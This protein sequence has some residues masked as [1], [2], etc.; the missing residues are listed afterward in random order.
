MKVKQFS[1]C[2]TSYNLIIYRESER[3]VFILCIA[4]DIYSYS[5]KKSNCSPYLFRT[6]QSNQNRAKE[7]LRL[8]I[9]LGKCQHAQ[10]KKTK[11]KQ[12]Q[13]TKVLHTLQIIYS[14]NSCSKPRALPHR[15][16]QTNPIQSKRRK[17][18]ITRWMKC[19]NA[20]FYRSPRRQSCGKTYN[21]YL[22]QQHLNE[23]TSKESTIKGSALTMKYP[24]IVY[25]KD[26]IDWS[27]CVYQFKSFRL[28][29]E[30]QPWD[31]HKCLSIDMARRMSDNDNAKI[32]VVVTSTKTDRTNSHSPTDYDSCC[33]CWWWWSI[34]MIGSTVLQLLLLHLSLRVA[35][36]RIRRKDR[37][38]RL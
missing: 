6:L 17:L 36:L 16:S 2:H 9:P 37:G 34:I 21:W 4:K 27:V 31:S 30:E 5:P 35:A 22:T 29:I 1:L 28:H 24:A 19:W 25:V 14:T 11:N 32:V 33:C 10:K 3:Q 7:L 12:K 13:K 18:P 38:K 26:V 15:P 8:L 20:L 23:I